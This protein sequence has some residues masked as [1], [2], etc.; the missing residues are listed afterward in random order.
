MKIC[1]TAQGADLE[2]KVEERFGRAPYFIIADSETGS[3]EAIA[4]PFINGSGG[5]GPKAA[6]LIIDRQAGVLISGL[7]GGN[8]KY[9]LDSAGITQY[10]YRGDG[11]V[12]A[13]LDA[14]KKNA[15]D[16]VN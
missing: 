3:F 7:L 1:I 15:F 14:F 11:T 8:A 5:V 4:N 16:Q 9:V 2:A 12:S 10:V 13:A 6:Q